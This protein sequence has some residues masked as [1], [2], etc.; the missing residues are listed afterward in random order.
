[1]A[2]PDEQHTA[3][4]HPPPPPRPDHQPTFT[5]WDIALWIGA[6]LVIP[7][8]I[9]AWRFL[10][11]TLIGNIKDRWKKMETDLEVLHKRTEDQE[12]RLV[13]LE[14]KDNG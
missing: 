4:G 9:G 13:K 8:V 5:A 11:G 10:W 1:M 6:L 3:V 14:A 7:L 2:H 12:I